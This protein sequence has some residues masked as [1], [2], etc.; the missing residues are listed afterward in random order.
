VEYPIEYHRVSIFL[1]FSQ[2]EDQDRCAALQRN[3]P[4]AVA[5]CDCDVLLSTDT[6]EFTFEAVSGGIAG[7][8][9]AGECVEEVDVA[10]GHLVDQVLWM[11]FVKQP[12]DY[13]KDVQS[14]DAQ[15]WP[16]AC[17]S[18]FRG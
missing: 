6:G 1:N 5:A 8:L 14:L 10:V 15:R 13:L 9:V 12:I 3:G 16:T 4:T 11:L 2:A 17:S 18:P 7:S